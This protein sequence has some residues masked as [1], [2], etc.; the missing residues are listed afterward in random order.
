MY[1]GTICASY[2][3]DNVLIF[4]EKGTENSQEF[5]ETKLKFGYQHM[6]SNFSK[7]CRPLALPLW[8][9][10]NFPACTVVN[11]KA[12]PKPICK[13]ECNLIQSSYC[14]VEYDGPA[15]RNFEDDLFP[16]CKRLPN[17]DPSQMNC[18]SLKRHVTSLTPGKFLIYSSCNT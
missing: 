3:Q 17:E 7:S 13:S 16:D 18:V 4:V 11:S 5:I 1:R 15:S 12:E 8:C 2:I 10:H 9:Y 14:K 6:V